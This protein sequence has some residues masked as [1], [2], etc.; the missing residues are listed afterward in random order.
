MYQVVLV[1]VTKLLPDSDESASSPTCELANG[2]AGD[3]VMGISQSQSQ[4]ESQ[5]ETPQILRDVRARDAEA[6]PDA[7]CSAS[8]EAAEPLVEL[9]SGEQGEILNAA[10][11]VE[12]VSTCTDSEIDDHGGSFY[13]SLRTAHELHRPRAIHTDFTPPELPVPAAVTPAEAQRYRPACDPL[14]P[15]RPPR[16]LSAST[17]SG[18][19]V[20]PSQPP[21]SLQE[22][23][24]WRQELVL[25]RLDV[26]QAELQQR[27]RHMAGTA[28]PQHSDSRMGSSSM[29][30]QSVGAHRTDT[31]PLLADPSPPA[32]SSCSRHSSCC[33]CFSFAAHAPRDSST[34]TFESC[35][36]LCTRAPTPSSLSSGVPRLQSRPAAV[37]CAFS[38]SSSSC[39]SSKRCRCP[40]QPPTPA[41]NRAVMAS[42]GALVA[43][44]AVR[45]EATME[46]R[47][48]ELVEQLLL[49][50]PDVGQSVV[51]RLFMLAFVMT[52]ALL[53]L[54]GPYVPRLF[55][56]VL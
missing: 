18:A 28:T 52:V 46:E 2:R 50:D 6:C 12:E 7:Y 43:T 44:A 17:S 15:P 10:D 3:A 45:Q 55:W 34:H 49:H 1:P 47:R 30:S 20:A 19:S 32:S 26:M 14:E 39:A 42:R 38:P 29:A 11:G 23:L 40:T 53:V 5:P 4:S 9:V 56:L 35:T 8:V 13:A 48:H 16:R 27:R 24:A 51:S 33:S 31:S 54:N 37:P 36:P 21:K 25:A 22:L 41:G